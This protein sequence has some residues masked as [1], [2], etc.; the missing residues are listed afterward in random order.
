MQRRNF[1]PLAA[2]PLTAADGWIE[3]FDGHSLNGWKAGGSQQS[4]KV[5]DGLLLGSG[6]VSH[7]YYAGPVQRAM[8]RNFEMEVEVRSEPAC[9]SG[10][11]FHTAFQE[12]GFPKKGFEVQINNTAL[13]EGSYRERKRTGSLYGIRNVYKQLVR[14][15]EWFRLRVSVREKNVQVWVNGLLG[16][17]YTEPT[18]AVRPPSQETER[19][20]DRGTFALQCH[21]PGSVVRFRSVRVRPLPDSPAPPS[22]AADDTFRR[23]LSLGVKN[24]PLVDW[25]V[26]LKP[27][28]D[29]GEALERSRRH[30]IACGVS[31]NC[32]RKSQ[33]QT[34]EQALAFVRAVSGTTAFVGMQAEGGDW[35]KVFSPATVAAFDY[36][37][38]DGMIWT[39]DRGRWTRLYRAEEIGPI[40][41]P[42]RFMDEHVERL[43]Q[44]LNEQ[45]LDIFAI[46][47]YLPD[48]I[49]GRREALWTETR[50]RRLIEAAAKNRVAIEINDR[51]RVPSERFLRMAKEAG[52]QF[53]LGTGN[54]AADDL[55]RCEYG[56][57]MIERCELRWQDFFV[58]GQKLR[59]N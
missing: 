35:Q 44:M 59:A 36:V 20:L 16:V 30:G 29:L 7:L 23:I 39:D 2:L 9:N 17:D 18:P 32:G 50:Q 26:H 25:H 40:A 33:L 3:L 28:L 8:F 41:N 31:A 12:S 49:A 34:N 27:G 48:S 15:Q 37:F 45:Q 19:F 56:L 47:T 11:Y 46:P 14:D 57:E 13:G 54:S 43:L 55:K 6:P 5:E 42:D 22:P 21:D 53:A 10:V 4:W 1:L 51:Y 58:P 52:C 38:N 24:Y